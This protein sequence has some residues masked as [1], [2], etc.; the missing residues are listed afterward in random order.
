MRYSSLA[1]C[2]APAQ[3]STMPRA[4]VG[5]IHFDRDAND[6]TEFLRLPLDEKIT[7][8]KKNR[9]PFYRNYVE[10]PEV[11]KEEIKGIIH[12]SLDYKSNQYWFYLAFFGV[13]SF[14]GFWFIGQITEAIIEIVREEKKMK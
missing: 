14:F 1:S 13:I 7:F 4:M 5:I 11:T 12:K 6:V 8:A 3:P 10:A 2:K 9:H